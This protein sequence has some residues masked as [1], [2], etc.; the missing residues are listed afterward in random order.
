MTYKYFIEHNGDCWQS[1]FPATEHE[2]SQLHG[3]SDDAFAYMHYECGVPA[4]AIRIV[5]V[6]RLLTAAR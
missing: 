2:K 1:V 6:A 5:P 4:D 3:D